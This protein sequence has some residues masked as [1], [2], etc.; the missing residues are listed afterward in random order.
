[1][2][3]ASEHAVKLTMRCACA[4]DTA[5]QIS[6]SASLNGTKLSSDSMSGVQHLDV[7]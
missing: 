5:L 6:M 2:Q 7:T 3:C 1:M 4:R